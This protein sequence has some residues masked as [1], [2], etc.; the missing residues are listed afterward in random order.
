VIEA[1]APGRVNLIG[2]HTDYND[3]FVLPCAIGYE[4][5]VT[6]RRRKD[7]TLEV[8][9][10][11]NTA[12]VALDAIPETRSGD[13]T[14]Y[15]R[16][17]LAELRAAGIDLN[18]AELEVRGTLP[19]GAGL[20]SSASFE[21]ALAL[22]LLGLASSSLEHAQLARLLQR[23]DTEYVGTRS[24]I[25]DQ[26]TVLHARAGSALF[27]DT[28]SL[29]FEHVVVPATVS[30]VI[31][32]SMIERPP[33]AAAASDERR[34]ECEQSV[35]RLRSRFRT[36]RALRDVSMEELMQSRDLLPSPL[37]ERSLH[38]VG[39]NR[40]V[41]EAAAALRGAD[42]ARLGALMLASHESLRTNYAV[43]CP[44]LD[45]L[46]RIAGESP[47]VYGARMIGVG[48]G[49][50]TVNLVKREQAEPF[51]RRIAKE[52]LRATGIAPE[53]YDGTPVA[54]AQLIRG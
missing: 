41:L 48:F 27:L 20:G 4:T 43:S 14:D 6:A 26:Y 54:G 9:S 22:A 7:R 51:R 17:V 1:R 46:V 10:G 50:C 45:T 39:E 18:A 24:E 21:A 5:C 25:T 15:V 28:R 38:V 33:T 13:W 47:G 36:I 37:F 23:V 32:N 16:G 44:E 53:F 30:I 52:Y 34:R 49:G 40:R 12:A 11:D 19:I 42:V 29:Q 2:E 8:R 3:G 35:V 31:C